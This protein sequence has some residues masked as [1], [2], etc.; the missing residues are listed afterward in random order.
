[1]PSLRTVRG[2]DVTDHKIYEVLNYYELILLPMSD[3]YSQH[4]LNMIPQMR[5]FVTDGR[6]EK[7][8]RWLGFMQGVMWARG[9]F[10]ID[11]LMDHN[12]PDGMEF[13]PA[14]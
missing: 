14:A 12:R 4:L 11:E 13:D 2:S 1:M 9:M 3:M 8:M 7:V 6:R 5:D 10:N